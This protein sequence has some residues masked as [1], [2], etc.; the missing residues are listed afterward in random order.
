[1]L[2]LDEKSQFTSY[3]QY[4]S[5]IRWFKILQLGEQQLSFSGH[6]YSVTGNFECDDLEKLN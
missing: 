5:D 1:M 2:I 6:E 4:I 3:F